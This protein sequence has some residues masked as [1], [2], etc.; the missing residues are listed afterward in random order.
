MHQ[1][2][3]VQGILRR[4]VGLASPP[5]GVLPAIAAYPN[6]MKTMTCL[7]VPWMGEMLTYPG[8]VAAPLPGPPRVDFAI[9]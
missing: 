3:R 1:V 6:R 2:P 4:L 9:N 5:E 8:G 7:M